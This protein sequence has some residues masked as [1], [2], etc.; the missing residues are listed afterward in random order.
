MIVAVRGGH[1]AGRAEL[2]AQVVDG[3]AEGWIGQHGRVDAVDRVDHGGVVAT[4]DAAADLGEA[5]VGELAREVHGD[6]AGGGHGRAAVA[7]DEGASF[8][9]ELSSGG[10]EDVA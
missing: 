1:Q 9:P 4:A 10:V 8:D 6:L 7:G 5:V 2:S 3:G